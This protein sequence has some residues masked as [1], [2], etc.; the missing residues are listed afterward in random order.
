MPEAAAWMLPLAESISDGVPIDWNAAEARATGDE[1]ELLRQLRVVADLAMLHR[2]LPADPST[3]VS[4]RSATRTP[5]KTIGTFGHLE[6]VERI[7]RGGAGEVYR[8]WDQQLE[9]EVALKLRRV[10]G[11]ANDPALS[12]ILKEGRLLA[13]IR[14]ANVIT[15]HGVTVHNGRF[16]LWM[17]L[18]R[19]STLEQVLAKQGPFSAREAALIGIDL[20]RALAAIHAAG[21]IHRDVKAQNVMREDGGRIL[22]MDLGMGRE[23]DPASCESLRDLAGTPLYLAPEIFDGSAASERTDLYSLGVLLYHLVTGTFPVKAATLNE[24]T[25]R[26]AKGSVVRLRDARADLPTAFVRVVDRAISRDPSERYASAGALEADLTKA[27]GDDARLPGDDSVAP[28]KTGKRAAWFMT[29]IAAMIAVAALGW[30]GIRDLVA[31]NV[32][33]G[34]IGSIAVL[35]MAN[36]SGDPSQEYFADGMTDALINDLAKIRSLRVISRTSIMQFKGTKSSLRDVATALNVDAVLEASVLR[37]GDRVRISAD[38]VEVASDRHVWVESYER[39]LDDVLA[40]QSELARTIARAVQIQLTPQEQRSLAM[41]QRVDPGVEDAYLQGRYYWNKRTQDG[42]DQALAHFQRAIELDPT[43]APAYAGQADV[44]NLLPRQ[45][46]PS[47]AYPLA[48]AAASKALELNPTL[49]EAHTSLGFATFAFDRDWAAAEAAFQRA[50]QFNPG[51]ATAHQWYGN[52]L[53]AMGRFDEA[54]AEYQQASA[55]DP[56]SS[57]IR[58]SIGATL[59]LARRYDEAIA[60]L[61]SSLDLDPEN[62]TAYTFLAGCYEQKGMLAE[63]AAEVRRALQLEPEDPYALAELARV[64]ALGGD[65]AEA[66]RI[67]SSLGERAV[68]ERIPGDAIAYIYVTLGDNDRALEFLGRAEQE[69]WTGLLWAAVAPEFDP[70]RGDPRFSQLMQKLQLVR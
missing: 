3:T 25:E 12:P 1:K 39:S 16:G 43:F 32:P 8:A 2:S 55:I 59:Y 19:G 52:Y 44:Y 51:Y 38:L 61:R 36:L 34:A 46:S 66:A 31:P 9:R 49:A 35:P 47:E 63:A 57:S 6:L 15:V 50:F 62:P 33:S 40:L 20:C 42:L 58:T 27:L 17:E 67:A 54:F 37:S 22:L 7:G 53:T 48:K 69:R 29:F 18:V 13:R 28:R 41:V 5:A 21:L 14:H 56:L 26:H 11:A 65:R 30:P 10:E 23:I 24:L 45:L 64:T 60:Q 4:V 68:K 70:I